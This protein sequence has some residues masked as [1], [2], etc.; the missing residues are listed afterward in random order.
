MITIPLSCILNAPF[1]LDL[2]SIGI[3][4]LSMHIDRLLYIGARLN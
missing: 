4:G 3:G 1:R 2:L